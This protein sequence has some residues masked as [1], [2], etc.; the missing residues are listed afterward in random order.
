M[1]RQVT[2]AALLVAGLSSGFGLTDITKP[3][4]LAR[5]REFLLELP[6]RVLH[7][8]VTYADLAHVSAGH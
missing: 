7:Y 4:H 1:R 3:H 5:D 8:D 6:T 2:V